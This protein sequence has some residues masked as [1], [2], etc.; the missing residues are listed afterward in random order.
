MEDGNYAIVQ[1][2][3]VN[4]GQ[5]ESLD[6]AARMQLVQQLGKVQGSTDM[7]AVMAALNEKASIQ[8]PERDYQ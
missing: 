8:I 6:E 5:L 2:E 1:L 3:E 7:S 4:D